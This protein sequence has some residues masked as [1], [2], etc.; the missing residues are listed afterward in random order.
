MLQAFAV[1]DAASNLDRSGKQQQPL[2]QG[3]FAGIG[4]EYDEDSSVALDLIG[5]QIFGHQ[6]HSLLCDCKF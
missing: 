4:V 2:S 1:F 3:G 6:N 5:C